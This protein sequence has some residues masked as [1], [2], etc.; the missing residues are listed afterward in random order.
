VKSV[1]SVDPD[2]ACAEGVSNL[3]GGCEV[4]G[5][6]S[7]GQAVGGVV[8][9]LDDIGLGL[10]LGDCADG[11]EDLLLLNLHVLGYVGEDGGLDEVAL[12]ALAL[13]ARLDRGTGLL[14][15]LDVGHDAVELELGDLRSLE[16]ILLEGVTDSVLGSTLPEPLKE[17]VVNLLLDVDTRTSAAALSVVEVDTKVDPVDSLIDVG[18]GKNNVRALATELE[19]NLLQV[20]A[21]SRLHDLATDNSGTSEGNLVNAHVSGHGGTGDLTETGNDVDHTRGKASLLDQCTGNVRRK[22]GLLSSLQDDCV[23]G[24]DGGTDLPCPHEDGEVPGNDLTADTN[25]LLADVVEC[26]GCCVDDLALDLIGPTSVVPQTS[27]GSRY[28]DVLGHAEGLAVVEG[29]DSSEKVGIL[30][31]QVGKLDKKLSAVLGCLLPP[32]PVESLAGRLN[33]DV[34]ILLA[35]LL[36]VCDNL[37]CGRVDNLECLAVNGLDELVVD[38]ETSGLVVLAR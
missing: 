30:E 2:G 4:S 14:A 9:D 29:L 27:S 1:V 37:F 22:R 26:V 31:E 12:V 13:A 7:G 18:I 3:D 24:G 21:S 5:V 8:A 33:G 25:R 36:D 32:W 34:N 11:T 35:G 28:I 38:E 15:L 17:L 19:G 10:E 16:G 6:D 23:T 20:G